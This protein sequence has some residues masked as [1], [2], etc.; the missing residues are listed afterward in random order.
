MTKFNSLIIS[1]APFPIICAP[2]ICKFLSTMILQKP[3]TSPCAIDFPLPLK[4]DMDLLYSI[5]LDIISS[6]VRPTD[7]ISG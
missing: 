6:S 2:S 3:L 4:F 7:A 5:P 1:V